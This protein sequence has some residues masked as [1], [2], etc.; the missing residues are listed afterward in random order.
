MQSFG[1]DDLPGH[2]EIHRKFIAEIVGLVESRRRGEPIEGKALLERLRNWL[3]GHIMGID[4]KYA[5]LYHKSRPT[6]G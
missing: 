5:E 4:R 3:T 1:Y 6:K 2:Q